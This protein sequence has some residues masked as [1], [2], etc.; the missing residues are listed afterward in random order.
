MTTMMRAA[1]INEFGAPDVLQVQE[2]SRPAVKPGNVLV[3]VVAAGVQLTDA[4]IR[5]GWTPPGVQIEFPQILGNEFAGVVE[6]V[7]ADVSGFEAGDEVA[8]FNLPSCYAEYVAVPS[9][10]IVAKPDGVPWQVAGA[11]SASGQTAHTAF[12]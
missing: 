9:S 7:G 1:A 5:S 3:R 2:V 10:Q 6:E 11:L 12:E 4:A 8:G